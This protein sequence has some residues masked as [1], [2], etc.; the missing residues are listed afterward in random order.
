MRD[1]RYFR[2]LRR[3]PRRGD[4]PHSLSRR[5]LLETLE[6]RLL[7]DGTQLT[8]ADRNALLAGLDAAGSNSDLAGWLDTLAHHGQLSE[9]L[10]ITNQ[11]IGTELD[12]ATAVRLGFI[13]PLAALLTPL[14]THTDVDIVD[15]LRDDVRDGIV[16]VYDFEIVSADGGFVGQR[17]SFDVVLAQ[18]LRTSHLQRRSDPRATRSGCRFQID[19]GLGK[20]RL[21]ARFRLYRWS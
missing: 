19:I 18:R 9:P 3:G 12:P 2:R 15:F 13:E 10:A 17:L 4:L 14:D 6:P 1:R 21:L 8:L 11:S 20:R 5:L 16:G 7:L